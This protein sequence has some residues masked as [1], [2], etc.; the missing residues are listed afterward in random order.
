MSKLIRVQ[1]N[2]VVASPMGAAPMVGA[3][4]AMAGAAVGAAPMVG[5][6]MAG[7][8]PMLGAAVG[9]SP[10]AEVSKMAGAASPMSGAA[11]G[12]S[13]AAGVSKCEVSTA[14][15][16]LSCLTSDKSADLCSSLATESKDINLNTLPGLTCNSKIQC[17]GNNRF[18]IIQTCPINKNEYNI[19]DANNNN[20]NVMN[21]T[22]NNNVNGFIDQKCKYNISMKDSNVI[23]K[24]T[25]CDLSTV[26][27]YAKNKN[28][29]STNCPTGFTLDEKA[30]KKN[31]S[32]SDC[33][34]GYKLTNN[35]CKRDSSKP[36]SYT[37]IDYSQYR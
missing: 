17:A 9:A 32:A 24:V 37:E 30:C 15:K 6:A 12:A 8:S 13:P 25:N 28:Y 34:P 19:I 22:K 36:Y 14:D 29:F 16:A 5:A 27:N 20:A 33:A 11:V 1:E 2:L 7:A 10:A 26:Q 4:T 18:N 31:Q 3:G 23:L 35:L 21:I